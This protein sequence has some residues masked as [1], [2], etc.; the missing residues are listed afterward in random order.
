MLNDII[1]IL[2]NHE[3]EEYSSDL[4]NVTKDKLGEI[5]DFQG[6]IIESDILITLL[7]CVGGKEGGDITGNFRSEQR[8]NKF[9]EL[10]NSMGLNC[11]VDFNPLLTQAENM[12]GLMGEEELDKLEERL[13]NSDVRAHV[14]MTQKDDY[15]TGFFRKMFFLQGKTVKYHR[16]YGRFLGFPEENINCFVFHHRNR[17]TKKLLKVL[18]RGK[19]EM[20]SDWELAE[21]NQEELSEEEYENLRAFIY[22]MYPDVDGT[23]EKALSKA[24]IRRK[25][26]EEKSID[27]DSYV[28]SFLDW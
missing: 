2:D 26:L 9:I 8:F 28:E 15:G 10:L 24:S 18:G 12:K 5:E 4:E 13:D 19:P 21:R 1:A 22:S 16:M 17:F 27:T 20:V 14:F 23:L 25:L 7:C 11:Y 6:E 3:F